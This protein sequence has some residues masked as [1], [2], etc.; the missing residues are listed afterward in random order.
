MATQPKP[1]RNPAVGT[2]GESGFGVVEKHR[3]IER[4]N[5]A[6]EERQQEDFG[7]GRRRVGREAVG[8]LPRGAEAERRI[9]EAAD[10]EGR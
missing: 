7:A 10:Q 5:Q 8:S 9:P 2:P 6:E 1:A 3:E 4:H